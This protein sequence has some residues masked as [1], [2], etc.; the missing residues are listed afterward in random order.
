MKKISIVISVYNEETNIPELVK[1]INDHKNS[2]L[3]YEIIFV[4]IKYLSLISKLPLMNQML[5]EYLSSIQS[6]LVLYTP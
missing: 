1:K 5:F 6:V 3:E 2:S 4:K